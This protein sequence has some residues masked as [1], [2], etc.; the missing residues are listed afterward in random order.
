VTFKVTLEIP[1]VTLCITGVNIQKLCTLRTDFVFWCVVFFCDFTC[2]SQKSV[3]I[4]LYS[5]N[6]LVC[7]AE[8]ECV[9]CAVRAESLTTFKINVV[10]KNFNSCS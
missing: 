1:E 2:I 5:I 10:S 9:S 3:I 7:T 4:L 6:L 8:R